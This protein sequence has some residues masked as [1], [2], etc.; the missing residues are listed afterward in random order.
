MTDLVDMSAAALLAGFAAK[1]VSPSEV[2]KR[3][4]GPDRGL[5]AADRSALCL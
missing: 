4:R 1:T 3:G 5:R 2:W